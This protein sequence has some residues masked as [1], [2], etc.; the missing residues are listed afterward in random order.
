MSM[1]I[2]KLKNMILNKFLHLRIFYTLQLRYLTPISLVI[3]LLLMFSSCEERTYVYDVNDVFVDANDAN[4]DKEKTVEQF[5]AILY[6][7][8]FQKA[9]SPNELVDAT[10][11]VASIGDKQI[12][13]ETIIAKFMNDSEAVVPSNSEMRNN[14]EQFIINTYERFFVRTPT[15]AEKLFFVNLIE[16]HPNITPEHIY[17]SFATSNEYAYY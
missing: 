14:I 10:E 12:A 2:F 7:N 11:I 1:L 4:K 3:G 9:L 15:E 16:S 5:I 8:L 13:Y 17:T 6:A